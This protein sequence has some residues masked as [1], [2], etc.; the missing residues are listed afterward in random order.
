MT[1]LDFETFGVSGMGI[2]I[3]LVLLFNFVPENRRAL[4]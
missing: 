4:F 3:G 2:D 1:V